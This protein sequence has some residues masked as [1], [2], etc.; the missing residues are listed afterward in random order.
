MA[1]LMTKRLM[2][3]MLL[4][5]RT[6]VKYTGNLVTDKVTGGVV[7]SLFPGISDKLAPPPPYDGVGPLYEAF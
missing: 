6:S 3:F 7:S 1:M 5:A 4:S 2:V